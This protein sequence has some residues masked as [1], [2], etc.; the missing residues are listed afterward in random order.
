M[1]IM[2]YY[3]SQMIDQTYEESIKINIEEIMR[4]D[5][6]SG[7][8]EEEIVVEEQ[9][10]NQKWFEKVG[11]FFVKSFEA[12]K[13]VVGNV[14]EGLTDSS[15]NLIA[16]AKATLNN[17][18]EGTVVMVV[19]T[20]VIP[21]FTLIVFLFFMKALLGVDINLTRPR[22]PTVKGLMKKYEEQTN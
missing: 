4:E 15:K 20:C 11:G 6:E 5:L 8:A 9:T 10:E 1:L 12:T 7:E 14:T 13:E 19:T 2:I 18:I 17:F 22:I 16:K 3:L 21:I